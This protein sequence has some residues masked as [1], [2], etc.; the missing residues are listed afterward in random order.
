MPNTLQPMRLSREEE[1]FLR[2]WMYDEVHYREG[3]GPAKRL[4]L[5]HQAVPADLAV[6]IAAAFPDLSDQEA[7]G[8]GPAPSE[9]PSWPW[10][11]DTLRARVA[12]ALDSLAANSA[13]AAPSP[14]D[15]PS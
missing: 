5:R 4:Q 8:S 15:A 12:E 13:N 9:P 6:L 14:T 2:H 11:E 1:L 3:Q 7:A 10:T